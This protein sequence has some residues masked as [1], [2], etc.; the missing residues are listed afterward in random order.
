MERS[1]KGAEGMLRELLD[2]DGESGKRPLND[3]EMAFIDSLDGRL[4]HLSGYLTPNQRA[5]LA[6]IWNAVLG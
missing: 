6:E 2:Y 5:K 3:W 1:D 4:Q